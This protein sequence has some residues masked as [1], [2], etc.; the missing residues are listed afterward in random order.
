M[1]ECFTKVTRGQKPGSSLSA[2]GIEDGLWV[3]PSPAG[4]LTPG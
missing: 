2:E 1:P 3:M 4:I